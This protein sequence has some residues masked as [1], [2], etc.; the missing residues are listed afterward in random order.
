[1]LSNKDAI[2][3][4]EDNSNINFIDPLYLEIANYAIDIYETNKDFDCGTLISVLQQS[5]NQKAPILIS[6]ITDLKSNEYSQPYSKE[7]MEDN[8]ES[9]KREYI[10]NKV[11]FKFRNE[12]YGKD[13]SE[14]AKILQNYVDSQKGDK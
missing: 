9:L 3:V 11:E 14:Q 10:K 6:I 13:Y 5:N 7:A 12:S 4:Y 8:L 1:M 2:K